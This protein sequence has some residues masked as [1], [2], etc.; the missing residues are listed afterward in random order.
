MLSPRGWTVTSRWAGSHNCDTSAVRPVPGHQPCYTA[1]LLSLKL[2]EEC[3]HF[4]AGSHNC[5]T[6]M[7]R[8]VPGNQPCCTAVLL[9]LKLKQELSNFYNNT[10]VLWCSN[11]KDNVYVLYPVITL[12]LCASYLKLKEEC[13][14]MH[15]P[16]TITLLMPYIERNLL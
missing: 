2:K 1:V 11:W 6:S 12:R 9:S 7:V 13:L 14:K 8:P 3:Q 5:K 15:V 10:A 16:L 4:K